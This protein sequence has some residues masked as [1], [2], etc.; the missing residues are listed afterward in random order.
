MD[1]ISDPAAIP[2]HVKREQLAQELAECTTLQAKVGL[3]GNQATL[4]NVIPTASE[5]VADAIA[6]MLEDAPQDSPERAELE[7]VRGK[8]LAE[9]DKYAAAAVSFKTAAELAGRRQDAELQ[10]KA[11][12]EWA[13]SLLTGTNLDLGIETLE[14]KRTQ[15]ENTVDLL[16]ETSYKQRLF[17]VVCNLSRLYVIKGFYSTALIAGNEAL[18]LI[19]YSTS[20]LKTFAVY[21][22]LATAHNNLGSFASA[23]HY[24]EL[25]IALAKREKSRTL[26]GKALINLVQH[27]LTQL[28]ADETTLRMLKDADS[29][30]RLDAQEP[31][32]LSITFSHVL[33]HTQSEE[34]ELATQYAQRVLALAA[35]RKVP[36]ISS[37]AHAFMA[38][39]LLKQDKLDE[40]LFHAEKAVESV[41]MLNNANQ[42][43][44]CLA[45]LAEAHK[46]L[47]QF[48]QGFTCLEEIVAIHNDQLVDSHK[49]LHAELQATVAV[50]SQRRETEIAKLEAEK[51]TLLAQQHEMQRKEVHRELVAKALKISETTNLLNSLKSSVAKVRNAKSKT[52]KTVL[53]DLTR[54]INNF[55]DDEQSR[56]TFEEEFSALFPN[57]IDLLSREYP[58]LTE[59]ELRICALIRLKISNDNVCRIMRIAKRSI[60]SYRY[61]IR[62]KLGLDRGTDLSAFLVGFGD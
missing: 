11:E 35:Q 19:E 57:Y 60:E 12:A 5:F 37:N 42:T 31:Q 3:L 10:F 6:E 24:Y 51:Q 29:Y 13:L 32:R 21:S 28:I 39:I 26:L 44:M 58:E 27:R 55:I 30:L 49:Q 43:R 62:K 15:L 20:S 41:R 61:R 36:A 9:Q 34:Y 16:D 38:K 33:Y 45:T 23:Q 48:E 2:Q 25:A 54:E 59:Q 8:A 18:S 47:G 22:S 53:L 52:V 17:L 14:K 7:Y 50:T 46:K 56:D 40:A 4:D 1:Y